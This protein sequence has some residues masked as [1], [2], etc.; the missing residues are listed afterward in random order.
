MQKGLFS[1]EESS[2]AIVLG[3]AWS[4]QEPGD[5]TKVDSNHN[6]RGGAF[7]LGVAVNRGPGEREETLVTWVRI[8]HNADE[9]QV[10]HVNEPL[11]LGLEIA[12]EW[13]KAKVPSRILADAPDG[14]PGELGDLSGQGGFQSGPFQAQYNGEPE[15]LG[16]GKLSVVAAVGL[17]FNAPGQEPLL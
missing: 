4:V 12:F 6:D 15:G 3:N 8:G 10:T 2:E 9:R 17:G 5:P 16:R 7:G 1:T 14:E 11:V 13:R